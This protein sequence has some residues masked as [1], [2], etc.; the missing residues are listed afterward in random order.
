M[1]E[2]A[3]TGRMVPYDELKNPRP[4][5]WTCKLWKELHKL[6]GTRWCGSH[7]KPLTIVALDGVSPLCRN[8]AERDPFE[9]IAMVQRDM[10]DRTGRVTIPTFWEED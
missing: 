5:E 4:P 6:N 10:D 7:D 8:G 1:R 9:F 2:M 3:P